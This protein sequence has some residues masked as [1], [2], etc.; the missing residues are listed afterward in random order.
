MPRGIFFRFLSPAKSYR[1]GGRLLALIV[2]HCYFVQYTSAIPLAASS[3]PNVYRLEEVV[4]PAAQRF[5]EWASTSH[6]FSAITD[7]IA[8]VQ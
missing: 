2:L 1:P 7:L 8:V 6:T 4:G 5:G 3:S